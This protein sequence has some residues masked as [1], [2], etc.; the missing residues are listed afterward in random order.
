MHLMVIAIHTGRAHNVSIMKNCSKV[1]LLSMN[2]LIA[3]GSNRHRQMIGMYN[4]FTAF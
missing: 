2:P 3:I 1:I 4:G